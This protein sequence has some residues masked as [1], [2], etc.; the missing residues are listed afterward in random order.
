MEGMGRHF[1]KSFPAL[2]ELN[3]DTKAQLEVI[4]DGSAVFRA[5]ARALWKSPA[6]A[7]ASAMPRVAQHQS[8]RR[9][10]RNPVCSIA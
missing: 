4:E 9:S 1:P 5:V 3:P 10:A 7:C 6:F 2:G 8:R